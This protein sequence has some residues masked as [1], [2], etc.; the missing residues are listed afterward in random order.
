MKAL[1]VKFSSDSPQE[2]DT[3]IL[4]TVVDNHDIDYLYKFN[5]GIDGIWTT[6]QDFSRDNSC[7]WR[8][9]SDGKYTIMV[10]GRAKDSKRPFDASFRVEYII[11][12]SEEEIING[13]FIEN[14]DILQGEKVEVMVETNLKPVMFKYW[15]SGR[16]G[17]ELIKDYT[18]ENEFIFTANEPG[19]HEIL[20]EC[21]TIESKN[22]FD[23]FKTVSFMVSEIEKPQIIDFKCLTS[24]LLT[25]EELIF[26]VEAM[27]ED[28]RTVLY[29]F[30]KID[31]RGRAL[32][33]Q[34]YSSKSLVSFRESEPGSYKL[35]CLAKDMYS[36]ADYD[37]RGLIYYEVKPYLPITIKSFTTDLCS[38]QNVQSK[39][40]LKAL[41]SGGRE[42]I[43]RYVIEGAYAEDT[44]YIRNNSFLW[45]PKEPGDYKLTL[46]VKD[47]SS[48]EEYEDR[49]SL[50]YLIER[51]AQKPVRIRSVVTNRERNFIKKE[52]VNIMVEAEGGSVLRYAFIAYKDGI[53]VEKINYG[54]GNWVSFT[55]QEAGE[56][57]MEIR[58][59][60]KYSFN[61]YDSHSFLNFKV[62]DY[63]KS[64]I[65]YILIPSKEYYM[66]EE[67]VELEVITEN[68]KDTLLKYF[69]SIGDR[70]V[71]ETEYIEEK[72]FKFIPRV[73]GKYTITIYSKNTSCTGEYDEKKETKLYIHEALPITGTKIKGSSVNAELNK[74]MSFVVHSEGGKEVLYEFYLMEKGQ[75]TLVQRYSR[76][77]FYSFIPFHKGS[78]KLLVLSKS[79]HKK[80]SYEDYDIFEFMVN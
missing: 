32:C 75:W 56:Y 25:G 35:L 47:I 11:G 44:G 52:P 59:K 22:S 53:E 58:V 60:D 14:P 16:D 73:S 46:M 62:N 50:N 74:A 10:Q 79:Y 57:Q 31:S 3:N 12:K 6:I 21:K 51:N 64:A 9:N 2:K 29:K 5:A 76:K 61:E 43:Y 80:L 72:R 40:L 39:I 48:G 55:P 19:K 68:T 23:D 49:Q 70:L 33:I 34:D 66:V 71:E 26:Q 13:V 77:N 28:S 4:I 38:P 42:L 24:E 36:T 41:V 63:K 15:I 30:I 27:H 37:D 78:Y 20:V 18:S 1:D 45:L 67:E 54:S 17:W 8:P 65:D 7:L 69:I